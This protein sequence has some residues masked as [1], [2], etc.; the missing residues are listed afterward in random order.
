[1]AGIIVA[2][3]YGKRPVYLLPAIFVFLGSAQDIDGGSNVAHVTSARVVQGLGWGAF[4]TLVL[5]SI[6]DIFLLS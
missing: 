5:G 1:M 3:L 2:K 6:L 4:D